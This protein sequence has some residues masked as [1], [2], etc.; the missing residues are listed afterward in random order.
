MCFPIVLLNS[1][2][3]IAACLLIL[4]PIQISNCEGEER[5]T[6]GMSIKRHIH[7]EPELMHANA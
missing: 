7:T 2:I 3:L 4:K 5:V 6:A 1:S